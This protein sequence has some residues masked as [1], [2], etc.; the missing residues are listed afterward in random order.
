MPSTIAPS[1]QQTTVDAPDPDAP[2]PRSFEELL[3]AAQE[4]VP[5]QI[6]DLEAM[7]GC[8][9]QCKKFFRLLGTSDQRSRVSGL[10]M[11]LSHA[12]GLYGVRGLGPN[13]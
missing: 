8:P 1:D 7:C 6:D 10:Y 13:R 3:K 11:Q 4:L 5:G 9:F 12:A 2:E